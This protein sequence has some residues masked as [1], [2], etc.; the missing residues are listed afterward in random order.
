MKI[1][2]LIADI[3]NLLVEGLPVEGPL[4]K[5]LSRWDLIAPWHAAVAAATPEQAAELGEIIIAKGRELF[6]VMPPS[7]CDLRKNIC[8]VLRCFSRNPRFKVAD[9]VFEAVVGAGVDEYTIL[10]LFNLLSE[11]VNKAKV[12]PTLCAQLALLLRRLLMI[13]QLT[14]SEETDSSISSCFAVAGRIAATGA[15]SDGDSWQYVD[16]KNQI[17]MVAMYMAPVVKEALQRQPY[18]YDIWWSIRNISFDDENV[19][20]HKLFELLGAAG[21]LLE[22]WMAD[23]SVADE[24][25]LE[26]LHAINN[27]VGCLG[28]W[29]S[30]TL[31]DQICGVIRTGDLKFKLLALRVMGHRFVAAGHLDRG[32]EQKAAAL[33]PDLLDLAESVS[34]TSVERCLGRTDAARKSD[35]STNYCNSC[36]SCIVTDLVHAASLAIAADEE[37]RFRLIALLFE[38]IGLYSPCRIPHTDK[39]DWSGAPASVV[40]MADIRDVFARVVYYFVQGAANSKDLVPID[41][42]GALTAQLSKRGLSAAALETYLN[43]NGVTIK[44]AV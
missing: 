26:C 12:T 25:V 2:Q 14:P 36:Q 15:V 11:Q 41:L 3:R 13:S 30:F 33:C 37:T 34:S 8:R 9:G 32:F 27:L 19:D 40:Q 21:E 38:F 1:N 6:E 22:K 43:A 23:K 35:G 44:S 7:T 18:C 39:T 28:G 31:Y 20:M 42:P 5:F 10:V 17:Q 16:A 24:T 4:I 29:S